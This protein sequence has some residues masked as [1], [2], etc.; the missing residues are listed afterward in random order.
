MNSQLKFITKGDNAVEDTLVI[1]TRPVQ[2]LNRVE[3]RP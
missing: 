2:E 3:I 1:L